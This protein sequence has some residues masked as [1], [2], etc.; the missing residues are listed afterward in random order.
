MT[1][2]GPLY[3]NRIFEF[4]KANCSVKNI[5]IRRV[6]GIGIY[7]RDDGETGFTLQYCNINNFG[8]A[9]IRCKDG[10]TNLLVENNT[11]HTG[12]QLTVYGKR[13]GILGWWN[14]FEN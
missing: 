4:R 7:L 11:I 8:N 2:T 5:E 12:Q 14:T 6:Y 10:D 1:K 13:A 3:W 9:A